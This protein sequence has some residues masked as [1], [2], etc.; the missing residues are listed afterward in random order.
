MAPAGE[1]SLTLL[2]FAII[3]LVW[4][5]TYLAIKFAIAGAPPFLMMSV[6][7]LLAGLALLAWSHI[8]SGAWPCRRTWLLC[9]P[10]GLLMVCL[11]TGMIGWVET[12]FD[13]GLTALIIATSPVWMVVFEALLPGGARPGWLGI[14]GLALGLLGG[15]ALIDPAE[16]LGGQKI[17]PLGAGMLIFACISW[18]IGALYSRH[19]K[20]PG[21]LLQQTSVQM[22]VGSGALLCLATAGGELARFD[23]AA[24]TLSSVGA[25]LYL[26]VFGSTLVFPAYFY[27][28]RHSTPAMVSTHVYVNP[29]IALFLGWAVLDEP[30]SERMAAAAAVILFSVYLIARD[31]RRADARKIPPPIAAGEA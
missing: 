16:L 11:G 6:R 5:S 13:S 21:T 15:A 30:I 8:K 1:R 9:A 22:I 14:A 7:F 4:G 20:L 17:D 31:K 3:Y 2:C 26:A 29:V 10:M 23:P 28:M 25:M 12:R 27:L 18:S 24:V 19:R